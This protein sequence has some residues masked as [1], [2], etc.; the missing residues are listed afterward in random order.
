MFA[1]YNLTASYVQYRTT[2]LN[3]ILGKFNLIDLSLTA[4]SAQ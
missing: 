4:L 1:R 3:C 2:K